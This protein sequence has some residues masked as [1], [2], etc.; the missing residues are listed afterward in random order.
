MNLLNNIEGYDNLIIDADKLTSVY[1]DFSKIQNAITI[2]NND[3]SC[4]KEI[5]SDKIISSKAANFIVV[6]NKYNKKGAGKGIMMKLKDIQK[7]TETTA[8]SLIEENIKF[9]D[10][11]YEMLFDSNFLKTEIHNIIKN[12]K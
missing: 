2:N 4:I 8:A 10:I 12:I 5:N 11:Q 6:I 3:F 9:S 1:I 7:L